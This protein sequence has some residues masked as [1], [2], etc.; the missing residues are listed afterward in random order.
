MDAAGET[1][2]GTLPGEENPEVGLLDPGCW[3]LCL[4]CDCS[5]E[6]IVAAVPGG[7]QGAELGAEAVKGE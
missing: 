4:G 5:K 6:G 3:G 1:P 2:V 7:P